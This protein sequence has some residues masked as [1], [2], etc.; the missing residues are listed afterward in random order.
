[1]SELRAETVVGSY[2]IEQVAGAGGMGVVY[3]ATDLGL[4]R[5]VALKLIS[6]SLADDPSFRERF[7]REAAIAAAIDHPN[8]IPVYEA[9]EADGRLFIAMRYVDGIDLE[10]LIEREGALAPARAVGIVE[11]VAAALDAAHRRDLIHRDIKPANVLIAEHDGEHVY[12]SDFGLT[13]YASSSDG[14]TRTGQFVGTLEYVAPEQVR[15]D[16]CDARTDVYALG[17]VLFRALTGQPPF[18]RD[19]DYATMTAHL[20]EPPPAV[21]AAAPHAPPAL[22]AVVAKALAKEPGDRFESAGALAR[23]AVGALG[24]ALPAAQAGREERRAK[25]HRSPGPG[26]RRLAIALGSLLVAALAAGAL[27]VGIVDDA[28]QAGS[29]ADGATQ[30]V[31][32]ERRGDERAD[33]SPPAPVASI[34]VGRGPEGIAVDGNAVWVVNARDDTLARINTGTNRLAGKPVPV[35]D[36]PDG[37]AAGKGTVWVTNAGEGSVQ[38]FQA[39]PN[40]I[41]AG[42]VRVGA[43]PEGISLGKQL[44]WT[45]S[46][47][48]D[49]VTRIDRASSQD[50]G[51]PIGVGDRPIGV[52]VG[53]DA[54]W[55]T[56]NADGTVTRIDTST[57][58]VRGTPIRVGRQPRGVVEG[59]GS[60]WV[61]NSGDDTVTRIDPATGRVVGPAIRVGH[62]PRELAVGAGFVWV[63][64]NDDNTVSRIDPA[65]GRVVGQAIPVGS[66]PLGVAVG[67][68]AVWVANHGDGTVT[69]IRA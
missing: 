56:N 10:A 4:Q 45:A 59:A 41:L 54:V 24:G 14:L 33:R 11:Q 22:D 60:V 65:S 49:T 30:A 35:G 51:S 15:G 61:A 8:V 68:G 58:E 31:A 64:N 28:D 37:V 17:C 18:P 55:V 44:V 43:A 53:E 57:A 27:A 36:D 50:V 12:L 23:A 13:R 32:G 63:A 34:R 2:R 39:R 26:R 40:A 21:T 3:R 47:R 66:K 19:S 7:Q 20:Q 69:R 52:F 67:A 48:E 5:P 9:G 16:R 25:P 46:S 38:R 1:M 29:G 62:N 42:S 6:S